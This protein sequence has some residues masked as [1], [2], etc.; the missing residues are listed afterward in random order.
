[1]TT[2]LT[3]EIVVVEETDQPKPIQDVN[4]IPH[5]IANRGI[6]YARN[7][8]LENAEG[9]LIVFLDDDCHIHDGW[10]NE[11]VKPF[12]DASILG[13]QGGV[14]VPETANSIGWAESML[15]FPGGGVQ[16]VVKSNGHNQETIEIS[17]LN[18]AYRRWIL[19]EVG[20]FDEKLKFGGED[21]LL[22]K[23]VVRFGSCLFVPTAA[24]SHEAR[25]SVKKIWQ[26]F[27]RRG[28]AEIGITRLGEYDKANHFALLKSSL[29]AKLLAVVLVGVCFLRFLPVLWISAAAAYLGIQ[30]VRYYHTWQKSSATK[31]AMLLLPFVK[32]TMDIAS[33]FGRIRGM[34]FD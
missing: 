29:I 21:Y 14:I 11:L 4:Y 20:H 18:C 25:G 9:D 13:V 16:R 5:S 1:M 26:W 23:R 33:D 8:A 28:R 32:L 17:T 31:T 15:G 27:V 22:S 34:I 24:V 6:A 19:D 7:L 3:F 30:F 2:S 10:L 12:N